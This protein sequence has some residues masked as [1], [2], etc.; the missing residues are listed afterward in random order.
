MYT[1]ILHYATLLCFALHYMIP[2][3]ITTDHINFSININ[4][5]L[6]KGTPKR[7]RYASYQYVTRTCPLFL[8]LSP[9]HIPYSQPHR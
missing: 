7:I 2:H 3:Y 1:V 5:T 8:P 9:I 6:H 4:I